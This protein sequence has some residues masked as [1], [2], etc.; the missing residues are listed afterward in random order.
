MPYYLCIHGTVNNN[1]TDENW[2]GCAY[3]QPSVGNTTD[4]D[5]EYPLRDVNG[6]L[7]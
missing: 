5:H 6:K 7:F 4:G 1:T 3:I 2:N